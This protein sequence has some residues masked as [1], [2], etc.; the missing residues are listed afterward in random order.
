MQTN[1]KMGKLQNL[2]IVTTITT[3]T[4]KTQSHKCCQFIERTA[5]SVAL[6]AIKDLQHTEDKEQVVLL[7]INPH[8]ILPQDHLC[9][10]V[11][12]FGGF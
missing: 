5:T 2:R 1:S 3:T 8:S 9:G 7:D 10:F 12:F 11:L 6:V 4:D